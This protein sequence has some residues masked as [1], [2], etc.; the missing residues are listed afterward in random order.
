MDDETNLNIFVFCNKVY[1]DAQF[2]FCR[3]S[4]VFFRVVRTQPVTEAAL[5]GLKLFW[6]WSYVKEKFACPCLS[7]WLGLS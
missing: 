6:L 2:S 3:N 5:V 1:Y 4:D 7:E